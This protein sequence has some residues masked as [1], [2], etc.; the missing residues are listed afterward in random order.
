M[1]RG[2][3]PA[4]EALRSVWEEKQAEFEKIFHRMATKPNKSAERDMRK[5]LR[6]LSGD[7]YIPYRNATLRAE[8][9]EARLQT[10]PF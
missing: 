4:N 8:E 6:S 1:A 9:S 7:V 3:T 5:L 2:I 10:Q